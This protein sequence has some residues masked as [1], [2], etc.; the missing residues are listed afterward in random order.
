MIRRRPL[1]RL[2]T[3]SSLEEMKK[4]KVNINSINKINNQIVQLQLK[5]NSIIDRYILLIKCNA[6]THKQFLLKKELEVAEDNLNISIKKKKNV[7]VTILD[8]L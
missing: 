4:Q 2:L 5:V 3:T 6:S 1:N 7:I 8:I